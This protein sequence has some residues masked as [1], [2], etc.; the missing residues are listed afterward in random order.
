MEILLPVLVLL[1]LMAFLCELIDTSIGGGYG[2]IMVPFAMGLGINP[3]VMIPAVLFSEICTGFLGGY[4][5]YRF[6][7]VDFRIVGLD[8]VLGFV[9]ISIGVF[10][11]VSIPSKVLNIWIGLIVL[12]CGIL[13]VF[14]LKEHYIVTGDF[15]LRN[16]VPLTL[17]C[18]FNK[19]ISGGG[20]GPVSTAGLMAVKASPKKAIGSTTLSEGIVCLMGFLIFSLVGKASI[21]LNTLTIVITTSASLAALLGAYITKRVPSEKLKFVVAVF[22]LCLGAW[23][24]YKAL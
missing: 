12:G 11:G 17:L 14:V 20:Y 6:K 9:G 3:L 18:S 2:T 23:T 24:L 1:S 10:L 13:M 19:G 21:H 4:G 8:S 5:H 15:K 22:M 16:D 7:N